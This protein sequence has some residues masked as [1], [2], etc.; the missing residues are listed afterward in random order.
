[1]YVIMFAVNKKERKKEIFCLHSSLNQGKINIFAHRVLTGQIFHVSRNIFARFP[2]LV[3]KN[4]IPSQIWI[5][6]LKVKKNENCN[7]KSGAKQ[8]LYSVTTKCVFNF[9]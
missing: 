9:R 6:I 1:M 2:L 7:V 8:S 3:S 4:R 5:K